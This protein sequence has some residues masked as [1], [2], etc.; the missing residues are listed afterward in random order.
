MRSLLSLCPSRAL[1]LL[2]ATALALSQVACAH[3]VVLEPSVVVQAHGRAPVYGAVHVPVYPQHVLRFD[4]VPPP[5]WGA[6]AR[7]APSRPWVYPGQHHRHL[8][9]TVR[10]WG[11]GGHRGR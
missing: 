10:G 11:H 3:P 4:V 8:D 7:V 1:S 5:V 2:G 6:P 9:G